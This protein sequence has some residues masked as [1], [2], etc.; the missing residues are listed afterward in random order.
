VVAKHPRMKGE[1]RKKYQV[2]MAVKKSAG[3]ASLRSGPDK[4]EGHP[5]LRARPP[6][7]SQTYKGLAAAKSWR[8]FSKFC[9]L[10]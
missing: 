9:T 5:R 4:S 1:G 6:A 8:N 10:P 3:A 7:Q 2:R